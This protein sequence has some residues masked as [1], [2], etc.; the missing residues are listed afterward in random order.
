MLTFTGGRGCEY[1]CTV[2]CR[3]SLGQARPGSRVVQAAFDT[4]P[5][6]PTV[7]HLLEILR[8]CTT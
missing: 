6:L 7:H 3:E 4:I 1:L 8:N 2:D 5:E